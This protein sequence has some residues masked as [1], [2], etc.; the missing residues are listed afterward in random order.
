[1]ELLN[2]AKLATDAPAKTSSLKQLA[3][4]VIRKDPSLLDEFLTLY[5][6]SRWIPR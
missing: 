2:G 5:W 4:L 1:M 6:S 3:E